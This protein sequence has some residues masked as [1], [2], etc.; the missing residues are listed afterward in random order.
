MLLIVPLALLGNGYEW[1][2]FGLF[3]IVPLVMGIIGYCPPYDWFGIQDV[4]GEGGEPNA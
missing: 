2:Y 1:A 3:G 4:P